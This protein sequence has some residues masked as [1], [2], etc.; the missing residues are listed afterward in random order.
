MDENK[1]EDKRSPG[2]F[3]HL[4]T[5]RPRTKEEVEETNRREYN[6]RR[7]KGRKDWWKKYLDDLPA[8][9]PPTGDR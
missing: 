4:A 5:S 2:P 7:G 8:L 3:A 6:R 9:K 1:P